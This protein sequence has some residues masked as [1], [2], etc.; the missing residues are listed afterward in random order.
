MKITFST[1]AVCIQMREMTD[2]ANERSCKKW[3]LLYVYFQLPIS[4]TYQQ[5]SS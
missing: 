1:S 5:W 3:Y 4:N 2:N